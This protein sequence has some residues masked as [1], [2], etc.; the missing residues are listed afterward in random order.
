MKIRITFEGTEFKPV[1][2]DTARETLNF[3]I[4]KSFPNIMSG[5]PNDKVLVMALKS[6]MDA[7]PSFPDPLIPTPVPP[8]EMQNG[9]PQISAAFQA[10]Q[11]FGRQYGCTYN[12]GPNPFAFG[13][14]D[15]IANFSTP[16][17]FTKMP[18]GLMLFMP[19]LADDQCN[20]DIKV[21][22][23]NNDGNIIFTDK[24]VK[25]GYRYIVPDTVTLEDVLAQAIKTKITNGDFC[26]K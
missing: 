22:V 16:K 8:F 15:L 6:Q 10:G 24:I 7:E 20:P 25:C 1:T 12:Q 14:T 23:L 19:F 13:P 9:H 18:E 4:G 3:F 5:L 11:Q 21:E 2:I 26:L 17:F